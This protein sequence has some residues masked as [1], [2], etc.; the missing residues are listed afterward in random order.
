MTITAPKSATKTK[1]LLKPPTQYGTS[2]DTDKEGR[3]QPQSFGIR[4]YIHQFYDWKSP[5]VLDEAEGW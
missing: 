1:E 2:A 5:A 4:S 3:S